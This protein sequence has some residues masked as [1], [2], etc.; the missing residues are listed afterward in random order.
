MKCVQRNETPRIHPFVVN[1]FLFLVLTY[2]TQKQRLKS[3]S[4]QPRIFKVNKIEMK[5]RIY[6]FMKGKNVN[7]V[8]LQTLLIRSIEPGLSLNLLFRRIGDYVGAI[9]HVSIFDTLM[10]FWVMHESP[11]HLLATSPTKRYRLTV[12]S[13]NLTIVFHVSCVN[14]ANH[15]LKLSLTRHEMQKNGCDRVKSW[16]VGD[17]RT[18]VA[19]DAHNSV[20]NSSA[21]LR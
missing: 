20:S 12:S 5:L 3:N 4:V 19:K 15:R 1:I 11:E 18:S 8:H 13:F 17:I 7:K 9:N 6:H 14:D 16:A 21:L 2:L 10:W